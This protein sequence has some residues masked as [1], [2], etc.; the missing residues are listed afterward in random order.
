VASIVV[1]LACI[2]VMAHAVRTDALGGFARHTPMGL[3]AGT[4]LQPKPEVGAD[5]APA[6]P[7]A[8]ETSKAPNPPAA[9]PGKSQRPGKQGQAPS[10]AQGSSESSPQ[11]HTKVHASTQPAGG[12]H[13][14]TPQPPASQT[15]DPVSVKPSPIAAPIP[16]PTPPVSAPTPSPT[17]T[18]APAPTRPGRG[19]AYGQGPGRDLA[20]A[21]TSAITTALTSA[22]DNSNGYGSRD[23]GS[24]DDSHGYGYGHDNGHDNGHGYGHDNGRSD[25]DRGGRGG[26]RSWR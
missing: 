3:I 11:S 6:I 8:T 25:D 18:P 1:V 24:D 14:G 4:V 13:T 7:S 17:P 16:T 22:R 20:N 12:T 21:I 15:P 10:G 26:H 23:H 5:A 19:P 9:T 2:G